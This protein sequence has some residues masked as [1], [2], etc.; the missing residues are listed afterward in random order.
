M[1]EVGFVVDDVSTRHMKSPT[2]Q[3]THSIQIPNNITIGLQTRAALSTFVL[4]RP[5]WDQWIHATSDQI[6]KISQ[7]NWNPQLHYEDMLTGSPD[8]VNSFNVN[9]TKSFVN[10][11]TPI[12]EPRPYLEQCLDS[13]SMALFDS[14]DQFHDTQTWDELDEHFHDTCEPPSTDTKD[15]IDTFLDDITYHQLTEKNEYINTMVYALQALEQIQNLEL[16]QLNLAWKPLEVIKKTLEATTQWA[17]QIVKYPLQKHHVSRFPWSNCQRLR[18]EVAMDTIF[19]QTP[20][21]DGSTCG[22]VFIG[23]MSRMI[24]FYPMK[25]KEVVHVVAAYQDFMRYEGVPEGLHRDAAPEEKVQKILDIN[26]EMRVKDTWSKA[27]HPNENPA[28]ALGVNPLMRGVEVLMNRTGADDRVWPWAYMYF[29]D[30]NNI[31][32]TPILG[33]KTPILVHHGYTPDISAYLLY[34]FWEPF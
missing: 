31:C 21:L 9:S 22:Q 26:R 7:E 1:R 23:L 24:N 28:E 19:M 4:S 27:G 33:W 32:A 10:I 25:S 17:K 12:S 30:I 13:V 11:P 5:S 16:I 14:S 34:Q 20:G 18:E 15:L 29:S 6:V 8:I 2:E 3:G